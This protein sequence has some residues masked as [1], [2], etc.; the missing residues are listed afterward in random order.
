MFGE[1]CRKVAAPDASDLAHAVAM[2]WRCWPSERR[3]A[4][5]K[6]HRLVLLGRGTGRQFA[7]EAEQCGCGFLIGEVFERYRG[8]E[9]GRGRVE[10]DAD[11]ILVAPRGQRIH[12]GA[13]F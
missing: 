4:K 1:G 5:F 10:A 11:K 3:G 9:V 2:G 12:H 6:A 7:E 8:G 13:E